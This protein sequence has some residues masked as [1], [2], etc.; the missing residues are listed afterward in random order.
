MT[1]FVP[2]E[3]P[4]GSHPADAAARVDSSV[5]AAVK[6]SD[7]LTKEEMKPFMQ[8]SD[9]RAWWMIFVNGLIFAAAFALPALWLNPLTVVISLLLLGGR[10]LGLAIF[11]HD[12]SHGV[13][14][15]T[16]WLNDVVG[17]WVAG[18]LLNTSMYAYRAYHLKHHQ[19]AGT[20]E[21]P[22]LGIAMAYPTTPASMKRKF[23][24]DLS[25]RTGLKSLKG[26]ILRF[27]PRRNLPFLLMHSALFGVL[28]LAG[29]PWAYALW[30]L[31]YLFVHQLITRLRF[32]GEHGVAIDLLELRRAGEHLHHAG[33]LVGTAAHCAQLRELPPRAPSERRGALL[34]AEGAA[35]AAR[36]ERLLRGLRLPLPGL[37]RC[38]DQGH[39]QAR[40]GAFARLTG[41]WDVA[42]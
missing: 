1:N 20:R 15:R 9:A 14:F 6:L 37:C 17:H 32:M 10:Q 40:P 27:R 11:Y 29:I 36:R 2:D 21:D 25:G 42:P 31:A 24:R 34:P 12:C 38:G 19:F 8:R 4:G 33:C 13:F 26:Q 23:S 7:V 30:W 39:A 41:S 22:D 16:R 28:W 3:I 35:R 18:G 5:G